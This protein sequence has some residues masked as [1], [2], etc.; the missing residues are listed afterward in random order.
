M[1]KSCVQFSV[2]SNLLGMI[3]FDKS[4]INDVHNDKR[5][6]SQ[7]FSVY[8]NVFNTQCIAHKLNESF[9]LFSSFSSLYL[10]QHSTYILKF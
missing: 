2:D 1:N 10:L 4:S 8:Q 7:Y 9:K 5:I 6:S 3:I